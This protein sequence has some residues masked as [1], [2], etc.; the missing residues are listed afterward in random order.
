MTKICLS[1]PPPHSSTANMFNLA[2]G[3]NLEISGSRW[4]M[5]SAGTLIICVRVWEEDS[6]TR[7]S[8]RQRCSSR[9]LEAMVTEKGVKALLWSLASSATDR[10]CL[11]PSRKAERTWRAQ[12]RVWN[13]N[14]FVIPFSTSFE[15]IEN[16]KIYEIL[17][18]K[19]KF[20]SNYY[21]FITLGNTEPILCFLSQ[22]FL[23]NSWVVAKHFLRAREDN[24]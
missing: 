6:A 15:Q 24:S 9:M 3:H 19:R 10:N 21:F 7:A 1:P 4:H 2:S 16:F 17:S 18:R 22:C 12:A 11:E 8:S 13:D 20:N 5:C 14:T 23:F